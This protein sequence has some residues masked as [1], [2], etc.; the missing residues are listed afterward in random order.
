MRN[1]K[2]RFQNYTVENIH[3]FPCEGW[4]GVRQIVYIVE[5]THNRFKATYYL[6]YLI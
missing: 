6:P 1:E 2:S 5:T 4:E 3:E